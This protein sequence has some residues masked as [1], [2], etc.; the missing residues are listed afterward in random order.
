M[1]AGDHDRTDTCG[2]A[3]FD[4]RRNFVTN[5]VDHTDKAEE[6]E[7]TFNLSRI[8]NVGICVIFTV[9]GSKNT[10]SLVGE[11]LVFCREILAILIGCRN[12]LAVLV[13][14]VSTI[15][16]NNVGSTGC[17]LNEFSVA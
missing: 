9:S 3:L 16:D 12:Y 5:G 2:T 10:Q 7:V 8:G 15:A 14:I 4:S 11:L 13:E 17:M 1:V 6:Y